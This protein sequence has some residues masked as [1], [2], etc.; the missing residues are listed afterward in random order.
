MRFFACLAG[1][2]VYKRQDFDVTDHIRLSVQGDAELMAALDAGREGLMADVLA[3]ELADGLTGVSKEWDIN[4]K[5]AVIT[6]A[7][8]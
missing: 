7:R 8:V 6:I 5:S 2:D 3:D 4:G 1:Q